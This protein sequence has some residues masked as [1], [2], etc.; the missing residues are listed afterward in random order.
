MT[1]ILAIILRF[2]IHLF[3]YDSCMNFE[4]LLATNN[5]H[6]LEEVRQ[7]LSPHGIIVYCISDLNLDYKEPIED[8]KTY[9]DNALIKADALKELTD[10]PIIADDSGLEIEALDNKLGLYSSRFASEL[11][12]YDNAFKYVLDKVKEKNNTKARFICDIILVNIEDRPLLF[13]GIC[14]GNIA[15]EVKGNDGFG[16]DPIFIPDGYDHSFAELE[17]NVKNSI[18]HRGRALK[19]LLTYLRLNGLIK[20]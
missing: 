17:R 9:K 3:W 19:K 12:G 8:G 1:D 20:K 2:I 13:E 14:E 18:S 5:K 11:G 7:I 4:I 6:K 16:Y 15:S 10:L